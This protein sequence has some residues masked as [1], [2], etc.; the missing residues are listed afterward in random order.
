MTGIQELQSYLLMA[1]AVA[2]AGLLRGFSGFGAGLVMVPALSLLAGP[3]LAV[4]TVILMEALAGSWLVPPAVRHARWKSILPLGAAAALTIPIGSLILGWLDPALLSKAISALVLLFAA[5]LWTGW[6]YQGN[7]G[8]GASFGI[9]A[10]S[11]ALTGSAGIGGPPVILFFLSGPTTAPG[12][13]ASLICYFA[14]TQV[15]ALAAFIAGGLVT[16]DVLMATLI[17]AP[18]FLVTTQ[19]G[20]RLFG[21]V[22]EKLFRAVALTLLSLVALAGLIPWRW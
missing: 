12:V 19:A 11:G 5:I 17:L 13:R 9:G 1:L 3:R 16:G 20:T 10:L 22:N 4:P 14:I 18:I 21:K 6:R 15:V 7:P 8:M 2:A